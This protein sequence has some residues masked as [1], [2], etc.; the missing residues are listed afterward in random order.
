M[1]L[2]EPQVHLE[3]LTDGRATWV[4]DAPAAKS[5]E[6]QTAP[7]NSTSGNGTSSNAGIAIGNFEIVDGSLTYLD[8]GSKTNEVINDIDV[9][10]EAASLVSGPFRAQG[11]LVAKSMRLGINAEIGEI[12]G[13]RTFPLDLGVTVGG[14]SAKLSLAG[15][16]LNLEEAPRFRGTMKLES[17]DIGKV[18]SALA[19]GAALPAP[20]SQSLLMNGTL[21]ASAAALALDPTLLA[22][23]LGRVELRELL[24]ADVVASTSRQLQHLAD[25]RLAP[26]ELIDSPNYRAARVFAANARR[27]G[28][29]VSKIPMPIDWNYALDETRWLQETAD[30]HG[31]PHGVVF[32]VDLAD[33]QD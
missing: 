4:F 12:V 2:V 25:D 15:T 31:F 1:R 11:S 30:K 14:E 24:D 32:Q 21:D 33:V 28:L 20:L 8:A 17:P 22:E 19:D 7:S 5:A 16:V 9:T 29:P 26:D 13:G 23:L 27:A 6:E 18:V 10:L 3:V